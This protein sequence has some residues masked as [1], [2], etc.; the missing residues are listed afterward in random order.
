MKYECDIIEDLLPLYKDKACSAA[1]S[2]AVE[3]HLAATGRAQQGAVQV[4]EFH[5]L[6]ELELDAVAVVIGLPGTAD[7]NALDSAGESQVL[8]EGELH[9]T[10]GDTDLLEIGIHLGFDGAGS[11]GARYVGEDIVAAELDSR[12]GIG[13]VAGKIHGIEVTGETVDNFGNGVAQV[14]GSERGTEAAEQAAEVLG[15]SCAG[16]HQSG[17]SDSN[18][19]LHNAYTI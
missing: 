14:G 16:E 9:G 6:A 17:S 5:G 4:E 2:K 19:F 10:G 11:G 15:R 1:S 13:P 7:R 3:E 8:V 18:H 12:T